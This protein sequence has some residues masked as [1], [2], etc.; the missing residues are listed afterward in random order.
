MLEL[1]VECLALLLAA[2]SPRVLYLSIDDV[3][4]WMYGWIDGM[5]LDLFGL[6][7]WMGLDRIGWDGM[8]VWMYKCA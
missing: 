7:E 3:H 1:A 8:D 4:G 2:I 5:G 6:D